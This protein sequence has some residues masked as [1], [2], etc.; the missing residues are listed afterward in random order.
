MN[1]KNNFIFVLKANVHIYEHLLLKIFNDKMNNH[2]VKKT[3]NVFL[4]HLNTFVERV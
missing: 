2:Y 1:N 4:L 3:N